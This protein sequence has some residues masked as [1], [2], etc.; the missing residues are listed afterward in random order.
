MWLQG[1]HSYI[2]KNWR[3]KLDQNFEKG[4]TLIFTESYDTRNIFNFKIY[5]EICITYIL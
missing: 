5:D 4:L 1:L 3:T 2:F